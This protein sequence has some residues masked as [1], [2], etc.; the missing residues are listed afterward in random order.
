MGV[1]KV[2]RPLGVWAR[3]IDIDE[4]VAEENHLK[5]SIRHG[6]G[7][8]LDVDDSGE[9]EY[10]AIVSVPE[11]SLPPLLSV[12]HWPLVHAYRGSRDV[13]RLYAF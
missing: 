12:I 6:P 9:G 1:K 13:R 8:A 7:A 5:P 11:T 3:R 10:V 2:L 4:S